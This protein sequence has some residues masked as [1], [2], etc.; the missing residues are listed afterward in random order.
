[1]PGLL[2][3]NKVDSWFVLAAIAFFGDFYNVHLSK[4]LQSLCRFFV[5]YRPELWKGFCR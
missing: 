3:K 1:M 5:Q 2:Q 4:K